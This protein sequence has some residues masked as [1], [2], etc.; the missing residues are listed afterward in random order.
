MIGFQVK[1]QVYLGIALIC[2]IV[3]VLLV[4]STSVNSSFW[5]LYQLKPVFLFYD[6]NNLKFF[7]LHQV[8]PQV[9]FFT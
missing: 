6:N 9:F 5:G 1:A 7:V 2:T 8:K 4:L 3:I